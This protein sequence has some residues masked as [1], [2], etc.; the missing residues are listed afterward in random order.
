MCTWVFVSLVLFILSARAKLNH[1]GSSELTRS[2]VPQKSREYV[3][4][5]SCICFSFFFVC[6]LFL[7]FVF[8]GSL[9]S[10][11]TIIETKQ[12]QGG[13]K[14]NKNHKMFFKT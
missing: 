4:I 6:F 2:G 7:V 1:T 9:Q 8:A 11:L 12:E 5:N 10:L 14:K 13:G 3:V